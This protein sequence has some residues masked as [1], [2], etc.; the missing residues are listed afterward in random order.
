MRKTNRIVLQITVALLPVMALAAQQTQVP[1]ASNLPGQ[2][3]VAY[4]TLKPLGH[5]TFAAIAVPGSGA[6]SN[7]GFIIGDA[8]VL[9]VDTYQKVD[10][11]RALL[12]EIRKMTALPVKYVVNTHYHIDHV[13]GN[14]VYAEAGATIFAHKNVREWIHTEN[15]KFYGANITPA[16]RASVEGLTAPTQVYDGNDDQVLQ[17]GSRRVIAH[18]FPGHTGGDTVVFDPEANFV[19]CGDL[20]WRHTLPN[21]IDASTRAWIDTLATLTQAHPAAAFVSGHG[22]VGTADDVTAFRGYLVDLRQYVT[23]GRAA[24]KTGDAL[25]EYLLPRMKEKYGE[26]G[27]FNNFSKR[28]ILDTDAEFAGTKKIPQP[29]A[30]H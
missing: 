1:A 29:V 2:A 27:A 5:N 12:A 26:W 10:A 16:Q 6:G 3:P 14:G 13:T 25:V 30:A 18:F 20:F 22:D 9:V 8:G 7:S 19:F 17:I 4:F 21:L 11:A 15:L 23:E 28:N 24:G